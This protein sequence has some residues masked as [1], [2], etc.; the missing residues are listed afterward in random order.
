MNKN[1]S[2]SLLFVLSS[3]V[4]IIIL[5][6]A[7]VISA[8]FISHIAAIVKENNLE[9]FQQQFFQSLQLVDSELQHMVNVAA[10]LTIDNEL[11]AGINL[12]QSNIAGKRLYGQDNVQEILSKAMQYNPNI[13][14]IVVYSNDYIYRYDNIFS[15]LNIYSNVIVEEEWFRSLRNGD[16]TSIFVPE[17]PIGDNLN[18]YIY[19]MSF[20]S[21]LKNNLET[22]NVVL[23]VMNSA[24]IHNI[25]KNVGLKDSSII[26]LVDDKGKLLYSNQ[27]INFNKFF[28]GSNPISYPSGEEQSIEGETYYVVKKSSENT[29]WHLISFTKTHELLADI[30]DVTNVIVWAVLIIS[31]IS[32]II[33]ILVIYSIT[34]PLKKIAIAMDNNSSLYTKNT[35]GLSS[36]YSE[37]QKISVSF[38]D[39]NQR[40]ANYIS[41]L[42]IK[43]EQRRIAEI[44]TLEAQI[45]PHFIYNTLDAIKWVAI[46]NKANI[47]AQM[48]SSFSK[49]LQISLS[50]GE[51]KIMLKQEIE[52]VKCY[53]QLMEYRYNYQLNVEYHIEEQTLNLYTLK[54]IL[55]P[56][57][58]NCMQHAFNNT[59]DVGKIM[60]TTSI[61]QHSKLG[62]VLMICIKDNGCG[63]AQ[64]VLKKSSRFNGMGIKNV[65]ERIKLYYGYDYGAKLS[66]AP[67]GG[68]IV[69][70]Y[71]PIQ[72]TVGTEVRDI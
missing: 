55:Q 26:C 70:I 31:A 48:V 18:C 42:K 36:R 34:N 5:F 50:S 40:L 22:K 29:G 37:I 2:L 53:I 11:E 64:E 27:D 45:N 7:F 62:E 20:S 4:I 51:S 25:V 65:D 54:L 44:E 3:W 17:Y 57:V 69:K 14:D 41:D 32:I 66:N 63:I 16:T 67:E 58:E 12:S 46:I 72:R 21:R 23:V 38:R 61:K 10:N 19:G 68:T 59:A 43:E 47:V 39:M 60:I 6:T 9:K 49:L 28:E 8:I 13:R 56:F 33:L 30:Y 24:K 52:H 15:Y 1:K 35:P 71:Q